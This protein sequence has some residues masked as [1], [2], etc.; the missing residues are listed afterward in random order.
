MRRRELQTAL[1]GQQ[2]IQRQQRG[3]MQE[4]LSEIRQEI[5]ECD[6][7]PSLL[8]EFELNAIEIAF[9]DGLGRTMDRRLRGL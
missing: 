9:M 2:Q 8:R 5:L 3:Q 7:N 4:I 1:E 6:V